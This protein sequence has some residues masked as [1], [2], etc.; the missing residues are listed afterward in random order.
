MKIAGETLR[1]DNKQHRGESRANSATGMGQ[2]VFHAFKNVET[3]SVRGRELQQECWVARY[4]HR[5]LLG[6]TDGV[7][8]FIAT[9]TC[10]S[11]HIWKKPCSP[12]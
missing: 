12:S 4:H 9:K 7:P 11:G 5:P 10:E 1:T 3:Q 2:L 6:A 8:C